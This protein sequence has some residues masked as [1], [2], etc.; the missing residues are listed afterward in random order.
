MFSQTSH[1]VDARKDPKGI[2]KLS[3]VWQTL[4]M[5]PHSPSYQGFRFPSQ[6][7]SH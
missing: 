7:I 4:S 5:N 6:I 2:V 3:W 1:L